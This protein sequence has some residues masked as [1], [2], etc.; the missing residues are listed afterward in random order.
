MCFYIKDNLKVQLFDDFYNLQDD[1]YIV[2]SILKSKEKTRIILDHINL[3]LDFFQAKAIK[4]NNQEMIRRYN[5]ISDLYINETPMTYEAIAETY[6]KHAKGQT[7]IF[8]CSVDH[9]EAIAEKI[10]GAVAV[11][12]KTK[13][14]DELIKKFTNRE[15]PV[16]VNC[17]IFT[18]GTDMPLVETVMI[19]RPTSNSSLYTQMVGRGLRLYPGKE[20]LTLIDLVGTTGRANLCT[21]PSLLGIDLNAVPASKQDE[22]IGDLFELPDLITKKADCPSSWIRNIEIV[23]LWAKEQEYNT[24]GVNYFKMP[25]GDMVVSIPKKKIRIPAQ[26]ELGKT[27]LG[28]KKVSMQKAFDEVYLYLKENCADYEYIWNIDSMRKWGRFPASEKQ[29]TQIKRF[30]KDFDAENLNKMQASQILNRLFCR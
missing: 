15:I 28:G 26:D 18:E 25:N 9:A 5:V 6:Y 22:I 17:M 1:A 10:P 4:T 24:H 23:D 19:A 29:I 8:A 12:A 2:A 3:C 7:L 13:N 21:A 20:K 11:T 30:M 27:T 14:R 16:L